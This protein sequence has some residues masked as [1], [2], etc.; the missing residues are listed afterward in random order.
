[1]PTHSRMTEH[2]EAEGPPRPTIPIQPIPIKARVIE[3]EDAHYVARV[4]NEGESAGC[5]FCPA[6]LCSVTRIPGKC[7]FCLVRID[8]PIPPGCPVTLAPLVITRDVASP[9]TPRASA[10]AP[11]GSPSAPA[12]PPAVRSGFRAPR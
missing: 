7:D 10:S 2:I 12:D 11:A 4:F 5:R 9:L 3:E 6:H 1:M 8:G